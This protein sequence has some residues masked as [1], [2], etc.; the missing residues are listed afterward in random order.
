MS[1]FLLFSL[2]DF[3]HL[4]GSCW[5]S[6]LVSGFSS[7]RIVNM[8]YRGEPLSA[9]KGLIYP[10]VYMGIGDMQEGEEGVELPLLY[11]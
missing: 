8:L 6:G 7:G 2:R 10:R 9:Q 1:F 4:L 3:S 5:E 11:L